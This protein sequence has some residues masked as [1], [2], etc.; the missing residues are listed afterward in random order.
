VGVSEFGLVGECG[1]VGVWV[2]ECVGEYVCVSSRV[3]VCVPMPKYVVGNCCSIFDCFAIILWF[4]YTAYSLRE[5]II[6]GQ[7]DSAYM[8]F[9]F[10]SVVSFHKFSVVFFIAC[11]MQGSAALP[12]EETR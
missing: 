12:I 11:I 1:C 5:S 9:D 10:I 8:I 3:R 6:P 2:F 7:K 4:R